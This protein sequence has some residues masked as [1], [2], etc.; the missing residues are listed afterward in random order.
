MKCCPLISF[1]KEH[2]GKNECMG[3]KCMFWDTE[4]S[5]CLF[6]TLII[7]QLTKPVVPSVEEK[8]SD[9]ER[10]IK[11]AQMGFGGVLS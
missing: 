4:H 5:T 9:L 6:K 7:T 1:Q 2:I 3:E 10:R 11:Y 8:I